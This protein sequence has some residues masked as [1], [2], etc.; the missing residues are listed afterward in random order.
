MISV[1]IPEHKEQQFVVPMLDII[2]RNVPSPKE[3]IFVSSAPYLDIPNKNKYQFAIRVIPNVMSSG[4]ARNIGAREAVG[5]TLLFMDCHVC[6]LSGFSYLLDTLKKNPEAVVTGGIQY[7]EFPSCPYGTNAAVGY[8]AHFSGWWRQWH[9]GA[10]DPKKDVFPVPVSCACFEMMR[11][12]T[13]YDSIW[14]FID[15]DGLGIE[16]ELNMRLLRFGHPTICDSRCIVGH[17]FKS[18]ETSK[19][20]RNN[21]YYAAAIATVLNVFDNTLYNQIAIDGR[22]TLGNGFDELM[23]KARQEYGE[24]RVIMSRFPHI[25][26]RLVLRVE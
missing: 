9:W 19:S 7:V 20:V 8:G 17:L 23:D 24:R 25:D 1:I 26:E 5:D 2:N 18:G 16:E 15:V 11:R 12:Q 6:F 22:N 21:V 13:F 4:K 10:K 14:G 3:V